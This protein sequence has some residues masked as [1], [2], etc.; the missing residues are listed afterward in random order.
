MAGEGRGPAHILKEFIGCCV[1]GQTVPGQRQ[2][3]NAILETDVI[4]IQAR[5]RDG[6]KRK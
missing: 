4:I 2:I 5:A 6:W 1:C 3:Q